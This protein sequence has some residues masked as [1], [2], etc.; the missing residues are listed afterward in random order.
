MFE[1]F[2]ARWHD[3]TWLSTAPCDKKVKLFKQRGD[4]PLNSSRQL[5]AF[6]DGNLRE[7]EINRPF[8]ATW[9][10]SVYLDAFQFK[11]SPRNIPADNERTTSC[12]RIMNSTCLFGQRSAFL[13]KREE[14]QNTFL[15]FI[16]STECSRCNIKAWNAGGTCRKQCCFVMYSSSETSSN[17]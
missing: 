14:P 6:D 8:P 11:M 13:Q 5:Q 15:R 17:I 1:L 10:L 2:E 7:T 3:L 4:C 16:I 12:V 9:S